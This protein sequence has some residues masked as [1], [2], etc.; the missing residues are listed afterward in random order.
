[1]TVPPDDLASDQ[2]DVEVRVEGWYPD[3]FG[4]HATRWWDGS[5]WTAYAAH[6]DQAVQWDPDPVESLVAVSPGLAGVVTGLVGYALAVGLS[7]AAVG[8][9]VLLDRPGGDAAATVV[10]QLGLWTGLIAACALVS[11]RR[12]TGSILRDFGF[13]FRWVDIGFGFAGAIAGRVV[14]AAFAAPLPV[15]ARRLRDIDDAAFVDDPHGMAA[16]I[17]LIVITCVGAPLVEELFFRGLLQTRLVGRYG[18]VTGIG[19]ASLLFGAAHMINWQGVDS[20]VY[21]W[22]IAGGGLVLGLLHHLTGRLG[23]AIMAHALFNA[24]AMVAIALLTT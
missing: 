21:A 20:F 11:H 6:A 17:I 8:V 16:W 19:V 14:S 5:S 10:S 24:M 12:G 1:M 2:S 13:R 23:P 15:S 22:A 7:V 3:P 9:L 18:A 4:R